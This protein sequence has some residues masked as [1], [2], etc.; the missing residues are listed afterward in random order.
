MIKTGE[1]QELTVVRNVDFG[2][3]LAEDDMSAECVLLPRKEVPVPCVTGD[4]L[5]VFVYR[6]SD[7]RPIATLRRPA[8]TLG[9]TAVLRVCDVTKIGAFLDWGL[10]KDLFL[11]FRQQ[12]GRVQKGDEVPVKLYLDKSGRLCASM[13]EADRQAVKDVPVRMYAY[14]RIEPDAEKILERMR[15]YH[16]IL[17]FDDRADPEVIRK[18]FDISKAAFKRAVGHLLKEEVIEIEEGIIRLR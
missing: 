18:E 3:Y 5:S 7:D 2:V 1:I 14:Q 6:D 15:E 10:E 4:V 8:L 9:E 16:G 12:I 13:K 11:P 17:P